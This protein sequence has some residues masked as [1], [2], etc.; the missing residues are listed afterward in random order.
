MKLIVGNQQFTVE[1][2]NDVDRAFLLLLEQETA[3]IATSWNRYDVSDPTRSMETMPVFVIEF[4]TK[5]EDLEEN[6]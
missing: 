6:Q 1:P 5:T 3:T 2:E 4:K